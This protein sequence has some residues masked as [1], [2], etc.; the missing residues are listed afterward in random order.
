MYATCVLCTEYKDHP[1]AS[2]QKRIVVLWWFNLVVFLSAVV[3]LVW[4]MLTRHP[5]D[6]GQVA[7]FSIVGGLSFAT[8]I[9]GGLRYVRENV[10]GRTGYWF[11]DKRGEPHVH[12]KC[13]MH[14]G[15]QWAYELG[16]T[17]PGPI[18]EVPI[19]GWDSG[20]S[21][22]N[23]GILSTQLTNWHIVGCTP[24]RVRVRD[25]D[26]NELALD[27]HD[28]LRYEAARLTYGNLKC[29]IAPSREVS[30]RFDCAMLLRSRERL[31][32]GICG[33]IQYLGESR[34]S[35]RSRVGQH[36]RELLEI[37]A[38]EEGVDTH[39]ALTMCALDQLE[40]AL[41]E[42]KATSNEAIETVSTG[43][44]GGEESN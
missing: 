31:A 14:K 22:L 43:L 24:N 8:M 34:D 35:Q 16:E 13:P 6:D 12:L 37:L 11:F 20:C 30:E 3:L 27:P 4:S 25:L 36:A 9:I 29:I 32:A 23:N 42:K 15:D 40:S 17:I 38:R 10:Y 39:P 33:V 44:R 2:F 7:Y 21:T 28:L 18:L 26:N 19:S 1:D 5:L 41:Q